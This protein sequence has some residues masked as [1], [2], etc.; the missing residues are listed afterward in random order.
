[1]F[2]RPAAPV[3]KRTSEYG[4]SHFRVVA[5]QP[6]VPEFLRPER[7]AS[8]CIQRHHGC[9][10]AY[11]LSRR[12]IT[13]FSF[14]LP[15][16]LLI[17]CTA[18]EDICSIRHAYNFSSRPQLVSGTDR[19]VAAWPMERTLAESYLK[20]YLGTVCSAPIGPTLFPRAHLCLPRCLPCTINMPEAAGSFSKCSSAA[21]V[22]V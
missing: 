20:H 4:T 18:I 5:G 7:M 21:T 17:S 22:Y 9:C 19:S 8:F 1:M 10:F 13:W 2:L 6:A 3:H 16:L 14:F 12:N 15:G 11:L